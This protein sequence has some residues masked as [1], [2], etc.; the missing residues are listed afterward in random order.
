MKM[1]N[2][3]IPMMVLSMIIA[4]GT[5]GAADKSPE[6]MAKIHAERMQLETSK[7]KALQQCDKFKNTSQENYNKCMSSSKARHET[8][9][10]FLMKDSDA[11]F[12][13]KQKRGK[14]DK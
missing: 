7:K 5:V 8:E 11:Y 6:E 10:H 1:Y 9:V 2:M 4:A 3:V 14:K 12:A 13:Q